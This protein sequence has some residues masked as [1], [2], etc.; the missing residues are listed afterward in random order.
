MAQTKEIFYTK[1]SNKNSNK[2]KADTP[3]KKFLMMI[4]QLVLA[5]AFLQVALNLFNQLLPELLILNG[6]L[7]SVL[8]IRAW[9][10]RNDWW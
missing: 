6:I 7:S 1:N 9:K 10:K 4:I 2:W 3:M 8:L 5:L